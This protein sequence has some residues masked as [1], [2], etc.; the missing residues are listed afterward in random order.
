MNLTPCIRIVKILS[1]ILQREAPS[2]AEKDEENAK[3]KESHHDFSKEI[4]IITD[5]LQDQVKIPTKRG[6][7]SNLSL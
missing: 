3:P 7:H 6:N 2:N 5:H 4:I 1:I